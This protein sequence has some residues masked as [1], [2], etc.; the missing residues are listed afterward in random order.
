MAITVWCMDVDA[1]LLCTP[2]SSNAS[3]Q[4]SIIVK[5]CDGCRTALKLD[6]F[7]LGLFID[8]KPIR[9]SVTSNPIMHFMQIYTSKRTLNF[10]SLKW[11]GRN[12]FA[13]DAVS[14]ESK[15]NRIFSLATTQRTNA[16]VN[17]TESPP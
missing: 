14:H 12:S 11:C 5:M 17:R 4:L 6:T 8:A 2:H 3:E 10:K 16:V 13:D 15:R 7:H 1:V 9:K